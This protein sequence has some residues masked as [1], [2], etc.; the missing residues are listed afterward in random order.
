MSR[1][2]RREGPQGA[3]VNSLA[4]GKRLA[5]LQTQLHQNPPEGSLRFPAK[6]PLC[7]DADPSGASLWRGQGG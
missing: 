5:P 1:A 4:P 6:P 7:G 3:D 2:P